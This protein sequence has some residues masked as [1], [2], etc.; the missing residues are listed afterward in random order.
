MV[1]QD[2][3]RKNDSMSRPSLDLT[4]LGTNTTNEKTSPSDLIPVNTKL[5]EP[6]PLTLPTDSPTLPTDFPEQ[7][8]RAHIPGDPDPDP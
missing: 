4:P 2:L 6:M 1:D 3:G 8:G 7:N 5:P